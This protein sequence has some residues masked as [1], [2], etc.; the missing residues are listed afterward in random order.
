MDIPLSL[1]NRKMAVESER[2][3]RFVSGR[4]LDKPTLVGS[5][6]KKDSDEIF[7]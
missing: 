3:F 7:M 1:L 6:D 2:L 4:S 5:F